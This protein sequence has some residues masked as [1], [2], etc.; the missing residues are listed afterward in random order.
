MGWDGC[1]LFGWLVGLDTRACEFCFASESCNCI[2][3]D[4][5]LFWDESKGKEN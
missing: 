1:G 2:M 5:F 4:F 3:C